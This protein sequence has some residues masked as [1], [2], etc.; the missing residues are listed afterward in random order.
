MRLRAYMLTPLCALSPSLTLR[1]LLIRLLC[2]PAAPLAAPSA[3]SP[4]GAYAPTPILNG[5]TQ[6]GKVLFF[7]TRSLN[8]TSIIQAHKAPS[9]FL[10][11]NAAGILLATASDKGTAIPVWSV[12]GA[13]KPN[14]FR[15]GTWETKI[16]SMNFDVVGTLLAVSSEFSSV[17][18]CKYVYMLV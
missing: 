3:Q 17:A 10:A 8:A 7:S 2:P 14:Q 5:A 16:Y 4:V 13:E 9:A 12:P 18:V 11:L 1:T 6:S 15:R